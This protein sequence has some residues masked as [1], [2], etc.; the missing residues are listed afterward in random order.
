MSKKMMLLALAAVSAVM[1]VLPAAASANWGVTPGNA[2]FTGSGPEGS[3]SASGEPTITCK[4]P[5]TGSGKYDGSG[6]TG[7]I[8]LHFTICST[9]VIFRFPCSTTATPKDETITVTGTFHNITIATPVPIRGILVT[10]E[11]TVIKCE[12]V[13][14]A[15]T[16]NGAVIG[17]VTSPTGACPLNTKTIGLKFGVTG[18]PATQVHKTIVG[19]ATEYDLTA[20]TAGG[21]AV[22]AALNATATNTFTNPKEVTID[23][24]TP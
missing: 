8:H 20:T 12:S 17:E 9:T 18:S 5:N 6:T 19:S 24:N 16:V 10:P 15:I 11:P 23:C 13:G 7:H 22:T 1:F 4:G 3:L 14:N 2:E 21:S